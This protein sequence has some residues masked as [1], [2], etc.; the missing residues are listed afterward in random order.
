M[1]IIAHAHT[2]TIIF[3]N[4]LEIP[5]KLM[6]LFLHSDS[7]INRTKQQEAKNL[8]L[9]PWKKTKAKTVEDLLLTNYNQ[10][11][12]L[13]YS[14]VHNDDDAGDIVQNA[15]YKAIKNCSQL[16]EQ[17]Y[18]STWLYRIVINEIFTFCSQKKT[19]PLEYTE[20]PL[21]ED[22]YEDIDLKQALESLPLEEKMI[23]ELKYF[24]D[25]KL[26]EIAAIL[27]LNVNTVKS[28]LYRSLKKLRLMLEEDWIYAESSMQHTAEQF[29]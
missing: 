20:E 26:E 1:C 11:F 12:R 13:A 23:V 10:Y 22:S 4:F 18:A 17:Q 21:S 3:S 24:E 2:E 8:G 16:K 27:D 5:I 9:L 19:E 15:A 25:M 7:L 28:R 29:S 14:Y 6:K